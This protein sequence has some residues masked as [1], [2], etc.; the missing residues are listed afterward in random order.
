MRVGERE[1]EESWKELAWVLD[2]LRRRVV[3]SLVRAISVNYRAAIAAGV[4]V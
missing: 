4:L 3:I 1:G 2:L